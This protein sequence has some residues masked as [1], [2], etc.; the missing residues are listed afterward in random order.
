[1]LG[2]KMFQ[3]SAFAALAQT[4]LVTENFG[5]G[6]DGA[7]DLFRPDESVETHGEV[8]IGRKTATNAQRESDFFFAVGEAFDSSQ[9]DVVY[10]GIGAPH[11]AAGD[12]HLKLARQIV[13]IGIASEQMRHFE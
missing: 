11:R 8:R 2:E 4:V 1:M 5:D 13:V 6:L 9:T 3:A 7:H 10:L 12:G